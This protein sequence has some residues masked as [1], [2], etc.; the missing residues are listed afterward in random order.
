MSVPPW[1]EN[2][3]IFK[4]VQQYTE[5]G[6]ITNILFVLI[7]TLIAVILQSSSAAMI[8][9]MTMALRGWIPFEIAAA[10]ILGENIGTTLTAEIA[11][12]VAN[13]HA[14][15]SARVH[16]LFN[17]LGSVWMLIVLPLI[18]HALAWFMTEVL[19]QGDPFQDIH[20]IPVALALFHTTFNILNA[21]VLMLLLPY[22]ILLAKMTIPSKQVSIEEKNHAPIIGNT[23]QSPELA[24]I[25][26]KKDI[27][28]FAEIISRMSSFIKDYFNSVDENDQ[29]ALLEKIDKYEDIT[30]RM[31]DEITEYITRLSK[32]E[33]T[34]RTSLRLRSLLTVGNEL[35]RIGDIFQEI[36]SGINKKFENKVWFNPQ[37][38]TNVNKM[39]SLI[40]HSINEALS[41]LRMDRYHDIDPNTSNSLNSKVVELSNQF[42]REYF[43]LSNQE[44][45]NIN[46]VVIY[47]TIL[48]SLSSIQKH[49]Q[50]ITDAVTNES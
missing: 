17:I 34:S 18:L 33:M 15:R 35:E 9:T 36:S 2:L 6:I 3:Q 28:H 4:W 29:N 10:L 39:M 21:I 44:D 1:E 7:G 27:V 26:L 43:D 38:R 40:D 45:L 23:I 24:T 5:S 13:V 46:S 25:E 19:K 20:A 47:N 48:N 50:E 41:N 22:L 11:A 31:R 14:K 32:S 12:L 49:I 42:R 16:T 30:D 37:Q 8:L